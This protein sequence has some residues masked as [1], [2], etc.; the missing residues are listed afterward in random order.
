MIGQHRL[1][2]PLY[3]ESFIGKCTNS[4]QLDARQANNERFIRLQLFAIVQQ[5]P[6]SESMNSRIA[7]SFSQKER[8]HRILV[9]WYLGFIEKESAHSFFL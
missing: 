3:T 2:T 9:K 1:Q 4:K 8:L 6:T 5:S 7:E